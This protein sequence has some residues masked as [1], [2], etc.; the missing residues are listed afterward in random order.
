ME[1]FTVQLQDVFSYKPIWVILA[2]ILLAGALAIIVVLII[3]LVKYQRSK[4]P[5]IKP[6]PP[7][8][9]EEIK[10]KYLNKLGKLRNE[11]ESGKLDMKQS[12]QKLSKVVR[13]FV[14]EATGIKVQF[15]TLADIERRNMRQL[16]ELIKECYEP[17]FAENSVANTL[18]SIDNAARI[19][20]NWWYKQ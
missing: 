6:V 10:G 2:A 7:K 1:N 5:K 16:S 19:I 15:Y 20:S 8:K 3:K 9:L 4:P 11:A 13:L 12:Y 17:E 14:F 18:A